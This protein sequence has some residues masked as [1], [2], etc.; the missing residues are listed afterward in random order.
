M[1]NTHGPTPV[2]FS[3]I[4]S[5]LEA[6]GAI[7]AIKS[8]FYKYDQTKYLIN[9]NM[10]ISLST[11]TAQELAHIDEEL[12]R[13]SD[14]TAKK[15]SELSHI[16]TPWKVAKEKE[17]LDYEFVFYRPDETSVGEYEPL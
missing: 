2:I 7:E 11:L 10:S 4:I 1:K 15:I 12:D 3:K 13:L 14:M 17:I 5:D 9:P 16:D 8:K 6:E